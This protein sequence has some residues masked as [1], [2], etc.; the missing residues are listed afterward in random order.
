M[1]GHMCKSILVICPQAITFCYLKEKSKKK[2]FSMVIQKKTIKR[3]EKRSFRE[4]QVQW[5][6]LFDHVCSLSGVCKINEG[7]LYAPH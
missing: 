2:A 3:K 1:V 7:G 4:K 6:L 5:A